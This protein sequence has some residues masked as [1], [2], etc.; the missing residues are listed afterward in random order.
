MRLSTDQVPALPRRLCTAALLGSILVAYGLPEPQFEAT[1][2]GIAVTVF[3]TSTEQ[4][5]SAQ[6]ESRPESQ[7]ESQPESGGEL[8]TKVLQLLANSAL[9]KRELS[10]AL[11][12]KAVSGQLNKVVRKLLAADL[13]EPTVPNQLNSRLQQY[14]LKRA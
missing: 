11:G 2:G 9:G 14:R 7:P 12:Q 6:P 1:Q 10:A 8:E 4:T 5:V 13:I 3:K